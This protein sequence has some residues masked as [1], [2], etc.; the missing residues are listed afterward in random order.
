MLI[1]QITPESV[2]PLITTSE[3]ARSLRLV[4][5]LSFCCKEIANDAF[6]LAVEPK[7]TVLVS[8]TAFWVP[9]SKIPLRNC[10]PVKPVTVSVMTLFET[11]RSFTFLIR[12]EYE[13]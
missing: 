11:V 3:I 4:L 5:S 9:R 2:L 1:P 12:I 7:L 6:A 10:E 8:T 13:P